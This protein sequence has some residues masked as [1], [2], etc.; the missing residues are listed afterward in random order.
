MCSGSQIDVITKEM[1]DCYKRYYG[2]NIIGI[3]LYILPAIYL[4]FKTISNR[5][6]FF[7][8]LQ[9]LCLFVSG[10]GLGISQVANTVFISCIGI[11]LAIITCKVKSLR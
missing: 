5:F 8:D 4:L 10:I 2:E 3:F 11:V 9:S 7:N 1:V 6:L